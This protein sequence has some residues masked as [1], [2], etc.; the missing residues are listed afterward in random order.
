[1]G[2]LRPLNARERDY[3]MAKKKL[4]NSFVINGKTYVGR[5]F[6]FD[7][8]CAFEEMGI[9]LGD[10]DRKHTLSVARAY[11]ALYNDNNLAWAAS[12]LQ[13]HIINKGSLAD[14]YE[15]FSNSMRESDFF[16]ALV[17]QG[18]ETETQ[19]SEETETE[20]EE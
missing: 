15:V 10:L 8:I 5:T 12:E 18:A 13:S 3:I 6:D 17:N 4:K 7:A 11:L 16:Q 2:F 1:M 19:Q 14:L 20:A 9:G